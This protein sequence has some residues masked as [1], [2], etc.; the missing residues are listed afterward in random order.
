MNVL[1][2]KTQLSKFVG[3]WESVQE[4]HFLLAKDKLY[5]MLLISVLVNLIRELYFYIVLV[6]VLM[7]GN[8]TNI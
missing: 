2:F 3:Q 7:R 6:I 8:V 5:S 1:L 4:L